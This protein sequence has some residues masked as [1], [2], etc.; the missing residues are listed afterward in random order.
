[1]PYGTGEKPMVG[2]R[3]RD[4]R[5]GAIGRVTDAQYGQAQWNGDDQVSVEWEGGGVGVGMS[6]AGRY[7]L[8]SRK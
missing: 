2:D 5:S 7:T 6:P 3:V 8:L 4:N 1:M